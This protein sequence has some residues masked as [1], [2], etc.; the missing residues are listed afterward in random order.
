MKIIFFILLGISLFGDDILTNYRINGIKEI[1]KKMDMKLA[2]KEYWSEYLQDKDTTFGYLETYSSILTCNKTDSTL[3]LYKRDENSTFKL[4]KEYAAYTGKKPGDKVKEGDLRTPIGIYEITKRLN[5]VDPF[6]G[7]MAFVTSYPNLYD[8]YRGKNGHGI[9][10]HGVPTEQNRDEFTKG[11]IAINN[12]AIESL[13]EK[14]KIDD[15]LLIIDE[16]EVSKNISKERLVTILSQLYMWRYSWLYNDIDTY[17]NFY[18]DDF[19]RADKMSLNQFKRYKTRIF[20]KN[21]SKTIIFND[22][23]IVRYPNTQNIFQITFNEIYRSKSFSFTGK[24]T[25]IVRMDT[26][27]NIKIF[28]EK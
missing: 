5:N 4:Q 19:S 17:L 28:I 14:I 3:N 11:C 8:K 23:N 26:L 18:A 13:D 22:I 21:E 16:A 25:L 27:N 1:E 7:P 20:R 6:Y 12:V 24:K 15:T 2:Q 9:W 10:I